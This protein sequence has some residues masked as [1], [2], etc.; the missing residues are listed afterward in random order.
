MFQKR[1]RHAEERA[2]IGPKVRRIA[3]YA[4]VSLVI[5]ALVVPMIIQ[6]GS[7]VDLAA[8]TAPVAASSEA[9]R[10]E[11]YR[12]YSPAT[13]NPQKQTMPI[14]RSKMEDILAED[15]LAEVVAEADPAFDAEEDVVQL[16]RFGGVV[17]EAPEKEQ[18]EI[19]ADDAFDAAAERELWKPRP[20]P[21]A[22]GGQMLSAQAEA[23]VV[24]SGLRERIAAL[25]LPADPTIEETAEALK[26][27]GQVPVLVHD[28]DGGTIVTIGVHFGLASSLHHNEHVYEPG[29]SVAAPT[30]TH[31]LLIPHPQR[32]SVEAY[33]DVSDTELERLACEEHPEVYYRAMLLTDYVVHEITGHRIKI[34]QLGE[35]S[36]FSVPAWK[37]E[38]IQENAC[39]GQD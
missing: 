10:L 24:A 13:E 14:S 6:P 12:G 39:F 37:P 25:D 11:R 38:T 23:L 28:V 33:D 27:L 5:V 9:E 16:N 30:Q 19:I 3:V 29:G 20:A 34:Y 1:G 4:V 35:P 22:D 18:S 2:P 26:R 21:Q 32:M 7:S 8:D 31:S 17:V 15:D 36:E